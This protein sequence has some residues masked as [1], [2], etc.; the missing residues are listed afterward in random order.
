MVKYLAVCF[1]TFMLAFG[2]VF[3]ADD[4]EAV[5][6]DACLKELGFYSGWGT[7]DVG[8]G[9]DTE[10]IRKYDNVYLAGR[11]GFNLKKCL[12]WKIPG[13]FLFMVEPFVNPVVKPSSNYE[14]GCSLGLK[15][16]YPVTSKFYPYIEGGTGGIYISERTRDQGSHANF[17]DH[18]GAGVYYFIKDNIA[19]NAGY[20]YRHISNLGIK[21]P[22]S[23]IDTNSVIAGVS[24]F[25]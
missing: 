8:R 2:T 10:P 14:A 24:L 20:R 9:S 1:I 3:A 15:Y 18:A 5:K 11:F 22:N 6:S 13:M 25:Y 17:V 23:G 21:K 19:L 4:N 16:A 12:N 7:A